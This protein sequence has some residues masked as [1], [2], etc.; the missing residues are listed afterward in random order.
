[1]TT[2]DRRIL[3]LFAVRVRE[4]FPYARILAYGS[5]ARGDATWESD[6][7]ICVIL[8]EF[9]HETE[10]AISE[11]SWE[12]GFDNDVVIT[13]VEFDEGTF[14]RQAEGRIPFVKN[15]LKDAVAA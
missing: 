3:D 2:E 5:R 15:I 8:Q 11:I 13:A 10:R 9:D 4:L 12:V 14:R 7:D 1:M 6:F